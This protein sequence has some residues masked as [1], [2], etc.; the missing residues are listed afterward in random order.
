MFLD[1]ARRVLLP[2]SLLTLAA[3]RCAQA[4]P[5]T[6]PAD[7]A[8]A[9]C[10]A[11][12]GID[13]SGVT[14]APTELNEA[15]LVKEAHE[16]V[17]EL[18]G[19]AKREFT[20]ALGNIQPFCRV[21]G[22]VTPAVGFVLMLPA[23]HW[24][25]KFLH[26]G[27][28]GWCGTTTWFGAACALHADYACIGTDMGHTGRGGL[29]SRNN[30]QAQL[31]FSYRATHVATLAGKAII[32]RYYAKPPSRSYFFGCSTGGFQALMEAQ[33]FPWD[34][35]GIM[36][37]DPDM[38]ER[39][40]AVRSIWL[41]R[42]F[43][44][45]DGEPVLNSAAILL[46]HEA[47]LAK[48]DMDDGVKDGIISDPVRCKFDPAV[49]QCKADPKSGCL[50]PRQVQ[51]VKSIYA[52]PKTSKGELIST[53]GAFPGS[54]L[55]WSQEFSR[56]WGESFFKET[57]LLSTAGKQWTYADFDFDRD[58]KRS[59]AGGMFSDTNPDL[60]R[61]KAA[62]G[63]LL[64]Y[65]GTNDDL[66][67][68]GALIDY[69]ETVQKTMGGRAETQDFFRLFLVPGM[70]HCGG[71]DGVFAFDYL[72]YLEAWVEQAW[73]PDVMIGAHVSGLGRYGEV[74]RYPLDP[75]TPVTFTRPVYPYP[76]HAKYKGT[77][78]LK[79]AASF[80]PVGP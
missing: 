30:L 36:A 25:G 44:G 23:S 40:L 10:Q 75:S 20:T 70:N 74:L 62:G 67:G 22:Y 4:E 49:L 24:N 38:D 35:D 6:V 32:E 28:G 77:G 55:N 63:K 78:D 76:L 52:A 16:L 57:G 59:G 66:E 61:F 60:R 9:R 15:K 79:R 2:V 54:E 21:S 34:F 26:L 80:V 3:M 42:S 18:K 5:V 31:D 13:F 48:C 45:E 72:G 53:R 65:Q 19:A 64:I 37:G 39:D 1:L 12:T 73:P 56:V 7:D 47:A 14:D 8:E 68:P 33:R 27:C 43:I 29:W 17:D 41:K 51:A 71:G 11:L 46:V 58:Y 50:T 69:Y